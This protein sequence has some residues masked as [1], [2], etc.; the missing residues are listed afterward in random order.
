[1]HPILLCTS[2]PVTNHKPKPT[3]PPQPRSCISSVDATSKSNTRV[4][5]GSMI[6]PCPAKSGK[7]RSR[8]A[9]KP[10]FE[11][12]GVMDAC[13]SRVSCYQM[14]L[15]HST[16]AFSTAVN[17]DLEHPIQPPELGIPP[18][19]ASYA[20]RFR[21]VKRQTSNVKPLQPPKP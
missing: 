2:N 15:Q 12:E 6:I 14:P 7:A 18:T 1:M 17:L 21:H 8:E 9:Q 4:R 3:S 10:R 5:H 19:F 16:S 20:L 13:T 11:G